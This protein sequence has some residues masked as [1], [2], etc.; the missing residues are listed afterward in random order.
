MATKNLVPRANGEGQLGTSAKGWKGFLSCDAG[1][2]S[3]TSGGMLQ[4]SCDDTA[5][6][7]DDHRLGV[8]YFKGAEDGAG[9]LSTGARIQAITRDAWGGSANDADLEFYTTDGTTE[10]KVLTLDADKLGT[11][12]GDIRVSGGDIYGP[13]DGDLTIT[14]DGN[15]VMNI[16]A[17]ND[18]TSQAFSIQN[19]GSDILAGTDTGN[20][21]AAGWVAGANYRTIYVDAGGMVPAGTN[22][23]Q[24]A[25]EE[26]HATNFTTMDYLAFDTS[27]EEY[28]DFKLVMPE[29]YNNSTIK[30]KFYWKPADQEASVSVVWG[31]KAYAATD[32]DVLTGASGVWG[33]EQVI[34]DESLNVNDDLHISSAT[35]ALTIAGSHSE[36]KLVFFRVFRKVG[37]AAD[38]YADDAHLLGINIQYQETGTGSA[39]W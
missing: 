15:I 8:I 13:V 11:F 39:A 36:G 31:I 23:A 14:S 3:A 32:S 19:S 24:A 37:A 30:V 26:M 17:D 34:E 5:A 35:P 9:T 22:G 10:S 28:A 18:E 29:Q 4:L 21:T 38:D 27:T 2:S 6:M 20:W 25:T 33:T 16:D 7:G 1:A 12:A